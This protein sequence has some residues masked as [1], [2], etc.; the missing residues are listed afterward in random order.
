MD[1]WL[2]AANDARSG[3]VVP[4]GISCRFFCLSCACQGMFHQFDLQQYVY[5]TQ[6]EIEY[7]Q[8]QKTSTLDIPITPVFW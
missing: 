8:Q 1:T 7:G 5:A 6:D 3:H 4:Q 2:C